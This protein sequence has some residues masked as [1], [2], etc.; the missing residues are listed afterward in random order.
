MKYKA[1]YFVLYFLESE[2]HLSNGSCIN[3]P[4]PFGQWGNLDTRIKVPVKKPVAK[5]CQLIW[6]E[7]YFM[8]D[9]E[10]AMTVFYLDLFKKIG[11]SS[12]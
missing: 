2:T 9:C 12:L 1:F 11:S 5:T 6:R 7:N 3:A 4:N 10:K 8:G